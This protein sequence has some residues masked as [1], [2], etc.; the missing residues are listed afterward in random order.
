MQRSYTADE[1]ERI[2][3][4]C[5]VL[6]GA[7]GRISSGTSGDIALSDLAIER[8]IEERARTF[9][10]A[11]VAAHEVEF[12]TDKFAG[13]YWNPAIRDCS[14]EAWTQYRCNSHYNNA[15]SDYAIYLQ[16]HWLIERKLLTT[17]P[18]DNL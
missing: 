10:I 14:D 9:V 3:K 15:F 5:I 1:L 2:R 6:V 8:I 7:K 17:L 18:G 11:G 12:L 4:A 13:E 16:R